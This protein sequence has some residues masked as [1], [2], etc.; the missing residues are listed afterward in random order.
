ML[1]IIWSVRR[2]YNVS[3]L[4][5]VHCSPDVEA[6][7]RSGVS[8]LI[9]DRTLEVGVVDVH[10]RVEEDVRPHGL[11][12]VDA[13]LIVGS[14]VRDDLGTLGDVLFDEAF[15]IVPNTGS[16]DDLVGVT[17]VV[18]CAEESKV[19]EDP[20]GYRIPWAPPTLHSDALE[21]FNHEVRRRASAS[22][23]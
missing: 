5:S 15:K 22:A 3:L 8:H 2:L 20:H 23:R 18:D 14:S 21:R 1:P 4:K 7:I 12:E 11:F 16:K 13:V 10:R 19:G 6:G 17:T 9:V